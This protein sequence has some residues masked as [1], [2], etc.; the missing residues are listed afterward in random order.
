MFLIVG[1]WFCS[2]N[3]NCTISFSSCLQLGMFFVFSNIF[4]F[5]WQHKNVERNSLGWLFSL[6]LE[7]TAWPLYLN[8]IGEKTVKQAKSFQ[9]EKTPRKQVQNLLQAFHCIY[10]LPCGPVRPRRGIQYLGSFRISSSGSSPR[11]KKSGRSDAKK[12]GDSQAA[13]G[14]HWPAKCALQGELDS[15]RDR[16][17]EKVSD[18]LSEC[19]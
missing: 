11:N 5:L 4:E 1:V 7:W 9:A 18:R 8:G 16:W 13:V 10:V 14:H 3:C 19:N 15:G 2:Q 6:Q 12:D 17:G